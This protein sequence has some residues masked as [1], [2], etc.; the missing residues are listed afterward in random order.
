MALDV[1]AAAY[2]YGL[3]TPERKTSRREDWES[4]EK[5]WQPSLR[6]TAVKENL[7]GSE[8]Y[9]DRFIPSRATFA[10]KNAGRALAARNGKATPS[11][12]PGGDGG[13]AELLEGEL[14]AV[15][16]ARKLRFKPAAQEQRPDAFSLEPVTLKAPAAPR[17]VR[18]VDPKPYQCLDAP[19]L[20]DDFYLN[21]VD[22]S[23]TNMVSVG[24]DR[25]VYLRNE[26]SRQVTKLEPERGSTKVT[27]VS[28]LEQGCH[29]AVGRDS[30]HVEVWD[31]AE[32]RILRRMEGHQQRAC[33]LA[34]NSYVLASSSR[35]R[36]ILLRDVRAKEHWNSRLSAHSGEVCGL[37]WSLDGQYL[38]SGANDN[39]VCVWRL[40]SHAPVLSIDEHQAAVK[41]LAWSPHRRGLLASGGGTRDQ[42]IHL[43]ET[44]GSCSKPISTVQTGSQVCNMTWLRNSNEIVSTHGYSLN[45]IQIWKC[46]SMSKVATLRGH[47]FRVLYLAQS[48]G[49]HTVVTGSGDET[50]RYW[51]V[52]KSEAR[53]NRQA[54]RSLW[55]ATIR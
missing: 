3:R 38:A 6:E 49:G 24:L 22:W 31:V 52:A 35:D 48:P 18:K 14:L 19:S 41:A 42:S 21:L 15:D 33:S 39:K 2:E 28:W 25:F 29:L 36:D 43:W 9:S 51:K 44:L 50:L 11:S 47:T 32:G 23:S 17:V 8:D 20:E 34:P 46:P 13:Y 10:S 26:Y 55:S 5:L 45:E 7:S 1:G 30:G 16:V 40:G 27:S 54:T 12:A 37:K 4:E 53:E